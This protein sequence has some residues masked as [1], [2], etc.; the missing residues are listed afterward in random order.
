[1]FGIGM[2]EM[3]LILAVALI[4]FGPKK[5]PELAK[6]MGRALG[7]FKR[8]TSDLKESIQAETGLDEVRKSLRETDQ[9]LRKSVSMIGQ[10]AVGEAEAET[11]STATP[12]GEAASE[13]APQDNPPK[14]NPADTMSQVRQAFERLNTDSA[15][16]EIKNTADSDD[17]SR[18]KDNGSGT[19]A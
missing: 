1:M 17:A 19:K 2:P 15:D 16:K 11:G 14:T 5:L 6:S 18:A 8:A 13:N 3:I 7:E 12:A 4:V 10:P 9:E